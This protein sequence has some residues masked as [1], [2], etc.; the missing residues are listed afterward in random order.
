MSYN[1]TSF[2]NFLE[3]WKYC[4][5]ALFTFSKTSSNN[6]YNLGCPDITISPNVDGHRCQRPKKFH[7]TP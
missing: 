1:S 6:R 4:D 2:G 3:H 7:N 5:K